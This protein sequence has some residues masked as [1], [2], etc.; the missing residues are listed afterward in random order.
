MSPTRYLIII[1]I[2]SSRTSVDLD[3]IPISTSPTDWFINYQFKLNVVVVVLLQIPTFSFFFLKRL[4]FSQQ[5]W[6]ISSYAVIYVDLYLRQVTL[7][8]DVH[9]MVSA[10]HTFM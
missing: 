5:Q 8:N 7:P 1:K 9:F 10:L 4:F 2:E 3:K 6:T